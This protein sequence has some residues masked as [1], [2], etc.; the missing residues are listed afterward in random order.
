M[1]IKSAVVKF[2]RSPITLNWQVTS[3]AEDVIPKEEMIWFVFKK[4]HQPATMHPLL[5]K[6]ISK[7]DAQGAVNY[8]SFQVKG[9]A[10][11]PYLSADH[12]SFVFKKNKLSV[13]KFDNIQTKG[14]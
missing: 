11:A 1:A 4:I 14:I 7:L 13:S 10:L 8:R 6:K 5:M 2:E 12:K 3:I 9:K